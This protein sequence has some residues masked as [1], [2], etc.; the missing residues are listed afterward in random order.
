M[1]LAPSNIEVLDSRYVIGETIA[2]GG[3]ATIVRAYDRRLGWAV[4]VKRA[5]ARTAEA[6]ARIREEAA[7]LARCAHP[8][9]VTCIDVTDDE[10][11]VP[12]LVMQL[13]DGAN[14]VQHAHNGAIDEDAARAWAIDL[15]RAVAYLHAHGIAHGDLK[16]QH[17]VVSRA[18][19]HAILVDFDR[20]HDVSMHD[21]PATGT[22]AYA[23]PEVRAGAPTSIAS[24][25]YA[26]GTVLRWLF[27]HTAS[28]CGASTAIRAVID[29]LTDDKPALRPSADA[30]M[31]ALASLT[32]SVDT[33]DRARN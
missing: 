2:V 10:A 7:I 19:G 9:I 22:E 12:Y 17:F 4:A 25:R 24:D 20:A 28:E 29:R 32:P 33:A 31:R 3:G 18:D 26:L 27:E 6:H 23:A 30:T 21:A 11:G 16:P 1:T 8:N 5:S 13:V 14:L 15:C